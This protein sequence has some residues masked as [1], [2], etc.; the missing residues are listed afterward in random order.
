MLEWWWAKNCIQHLRNAS[1]VLALLVKLI[2]SLFSNLLLIS[3]LL[4]RIWVYLCLVSSFKVGLWR[5]YSVIINA[6]KLGFVVDCWGRKEN[7]SVL[8]LVK[9]NFGVLGTI[10]MRFF[11]FFHLSSNFLSLFTN[12]IFSIVYERFLNILLRKRNVKNSDND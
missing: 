10:K 9:D 5:L 4:H 12:S 3:G 6:G 8:A 11:F 7:W 2:S 1:L